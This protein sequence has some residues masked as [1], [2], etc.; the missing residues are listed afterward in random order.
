VIPLE[1]I[2]ARTSELVIYVS[3][4]TVYPA[5]FEFEVQVVAGDKESALDP[6]GID[7]RISMQET[8]EISPELLRLGFEFSDGPK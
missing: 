6:F 7:H 8:S 2:V 5:G 3:H 1:E 4:F